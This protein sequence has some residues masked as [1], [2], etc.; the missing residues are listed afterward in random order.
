M[1]WTISALYVWCQNGRNLMSTSPS[2]GIWCAPNKFSYTS[3]MYSWHMHKHTKNT[4]T[5]THRAFHVLPQSVP[6]AIRPWQA[7]AWRVSFPDLVE[8]R[9][10]DRGEQAKWI[11][12]SQ[13]THVGVCV[14]FSACMP[15]LNLCVSPLVFYTSLKRIFPSTNC[16]WYL[17]LCV[18]Y[19]H[20]CVHPGAHTSKNSPSQQ[21]RWQALE[22]ILCIVSSSRTTRVRMS[23]AHS[24]TLKL[25]MSLPS[26]RCGGLC[27]P[28]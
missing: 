12:E 21:T 19:V 4:H 10:H 14:L 28:I 2:H 26:S 16:S 9:R 3:C 7:V 5:H 23:Q 1:S 24:A 15:C 13:V 20:R 22:S 25:S 8:S 27:C 18:V 17:Y 11:W 6:Q